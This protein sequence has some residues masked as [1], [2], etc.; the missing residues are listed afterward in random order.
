[1]P[2]TRIRTRWLSAAIAVV[3]ISAAA[4]YHFTSAPVFDHN[5]VYRIG[6]GGDRPLHFADKNGNPAGLA[7]GM[8]QEAARRRGIHLTW[9][10]AQHPGMDAILQNEVDFWILMADLPERRRLVHI[11]EPFLVT[12]YCFLVLADGPYRKADDLLRARISYPGFGAQ[13]LIVPRLFPQATLAVSGSPGSAFDALRDGKVDAAFLDQYSAGDFA[14]LGDQAKKMRIIP[15]PAPRSYMGLASRFETQAGVDEIRSEMRV[16]AAEGT[17]APLFEGWGFFPGLNLE[18]M[19]GIALAKRR[20]RYLIGGVAALIMLLACSVILVVGLRRQHAQLR[21]AESAVRESEDRFRTLA[22]ASLEG[23][24]IHDGRA[25][26]DANEAC[27]RL[28][29]YRHP[30]EL[31]GLNPAEAVLTPD[32]EAQV[33]ERILN[34]KTGV[35]EVIA[36]RNDGSTFPAET[37]TLEMK[38]LGRNAHLV[39][40]RDLTERRQA[41]AAFRESEE[42]YRALFE[43]SLDCVFLTDFSGRFLDANQAALD[44]L[45]YGREEIRTISFESMLSPDQMPQ[46]WQALDEILTHGYELQRR[47]FRLRRR[48]GGWV[49]VETHSS[50]I[51]RDG[52][53]QAL[54]G[55]ARDITERKRAEEETARLQAQLHQANK[56]ESIGRLAGGVAHDFNNLLTV[57]LGYADMVLTRIDT[58]IP[59]P[60]SQVRKA[61]EQISRAAT[62]AA[63]LTSQLLT[64]SRRNPSAPKVI[65]LNDIVL[66]VDGMLRPL[67]GAQIEVV[68]SPGPEAGCI[69]ADPGLL[70]QVIVNLAVNARDAMPEGGRLFIETSRAVMI[71]ESNADCISVPRGTYASL[72][73]T[74]TGTGMTPEVQARVFEPFFTTKDTGKGTGLGLATVYGIVK[75]S[76]GYITVQST[77]GAGTA[78]RILFPAVDDNA[79]LEA[80][81]NVDAGAE[82]LVHTTVQG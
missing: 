40:W 81:G 66:G 14:H 64:F 29:G 21:N 2:L 1:L 37:E 56:M 60:E 69:H 44:L 73:V 26:L 4:A 61:L 72:W 12:E 78:F 79:A 22:N 65:R 16:M 59:L 46:A 24:L 62:R 6:Y 49:F 47:E 28:F 57:I 54:Q 41:V 27:A 15:V 80:S 68:F 53:P 74:D 39:A 82:A 45:G 50:L 18:A 58:Q 76:G 11:S 34:R 35:F 77:P 48:D 9:V 51:F 70:E 17:L 25:I 30:S 63:A 52:K 32:S 43:R 3:I 20:E 33:K 5:R 13:Q 7:V 8:V 71:T 19:D 55:I 75:Q 38:Y 23:I 36:L 10:L 67:I 42:R 31:I